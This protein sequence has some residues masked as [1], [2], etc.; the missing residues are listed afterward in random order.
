MTEDVAR[1]RLEKQGYVV[2]ELKRVDDSFAAT[3]EKDGKTQSI[4]LHAV[5]GEIVK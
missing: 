1:V 3:V 2:H 5:T 4:R